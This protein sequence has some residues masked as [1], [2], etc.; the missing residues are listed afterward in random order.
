MITIRKIAEILFILLVLFTLLF[1]FIGYGTLIKESIMKFLGMETKSEITEEKNIQAKR[2]FENLKKQI[3]KCQDSTDNNCGCLI[4]LN[5]FNNNYKISFDDSKVRLLNIKN[6]R[7]EETGL[8]MDHFNKKLNCYWN[9]KF[10]ENS[11]TDI[12]FNPK[13]FILKEKKLWWDSKYKFTHD[14]NILKR[15]NKLCWLTDQVKENQII[16]YKKC[17]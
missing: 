11:F 15:N 4:N 10:I 8:Q 13:P 7:K 5:K 14:F 2:A 1:M 17:Q 3:K 9:N 12:L 6:I 16:Q